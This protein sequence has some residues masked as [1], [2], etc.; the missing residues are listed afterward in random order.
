MTSVMP[1][2]LGPQSGVEARQRV[3][4]AFEVVL[5]M[6]DGA[7]AEW[8]DRH[9]ADAPQLALRTHR[10]IAAER[11][12]RKLFDALQSQRDRV[13]GA[14]VPEISRA[15]DEDPRIGRHY[16]PWRVMR[17]LGS[18]GLSEVYAV[19][20]DDGRYEQDA[21]LKILR[22]GHLGA[23]AKAL[24]LRERR[25]L[26]SLSHPALVRIIDGGETATGSPWLVMEQIE[27]GPITTYATDHSLSQ[28]SRL[29]LVAQCADALQAAHERGILHGDIKPDHLLVQADGKVRLLDFGIAQ[30]LDEDG[31]AGE[32]AALTPA[33]AS[34]EQYDGQRLTTAS[35]IFQLGKVLE[36]LTAQEAPGPDLAAIIAHS[37]APDPA[38]RYRSAA[39]LAT[40][41][42]RLRQGLATEA[43][44]DSAP[45]AVLRLMRQN[46]LAAA[47]AVLVLVSL[48]GWGVTATIGAWRI[49]RAR[50]AALLA[51]D[52][53]ERGRQA[54][55]DLFRRADPLELD[56]TGPVSPQS[57][58]IIDEALADAKQRLADDPALLSELSGWAARLHRRAEQSDRAA[59]LADDAE[60]YAKAAYGAD[61][62]D[63]AAAL[64]FRARLAMERGDADRG[65]AD[66]ARALAIIDNAGAEDKP[67]LE[68]LLLAAW[69]QEGDWQAQLA[70]FRRIAELAEALDIDNARIEAGSGI[71]RALDGLGRR[72]EAEKQVK[73]VLALAEKRYGPDHPRLTLPLSD[74]GRI[75][76]HAGKAGEAA[77]WHRR[78]RDIAIAAYGPNSPEVLSHRNNLALALQSAGDLPGAAREM[79]AVYHIVASGDGPD[80]ITTGE[81]AQNLGAILVRMGQFNEAEEMLDIAEHSFAR[82]LPTGHPRRAFP[83]LTHSQMR[84]AQQRWPEAEAEAGKALEI[85]HTA[86]PAG[87]Y[88]IA[89]AQCRI[90]MARLE[91][92]D[93]AAGALLREAVAAMDTAGSSVPEIYAAPCRAALLRLSR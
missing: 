53:A 49:D 86:L 13:L 54:L 78:A 8:I 34:P 4:S 35:D 46:R 6:P 26:A 15:R 33:S 58:A 9:F 41:L 90:A 32:A 56:A 22:S 29:D 45:R 91:Q 92:G 79:R 12:S 27:G 63:Y 93:R 62:S 71:G 60:A 20:R 38:A 14:A 18:G 76:E 66:M 67:A 40:D 80:A 2:N 5:E 70:L 10:L 17:H 75:A 64:A 48:A 3:D 65:S 24:F 88:A 31:A 43:R 59:Q 81:V 85:L 23:E 16:G 25:M 39:A 69:S 1:D 68:T 50:Q 36:E 89:T 57:L 42:R 19:V 87:H 21:A 72:G 52:R 44:P 51:A 55:L 61:S 77:R 30:L 7:R 47:L 73:S 11:R 37:T 83:A 74:L 28:E 84:L 82:N